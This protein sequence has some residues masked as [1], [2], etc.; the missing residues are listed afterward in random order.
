MTKETFFPTLRRSIQLIFLGFSMSAAVGIAES[1][2][3]V[4]SKLQTYCRS[5]HGVSPLRFFYSEDPGQFMQELCVRIAPNSQKTWAQ[6]II[7]VISWPTDQAP[8]PTQVMEP[9]SRDWMPRGA[10]RFAFSM[11]QHEGQL[12]RHILIDVVRNQCGL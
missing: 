7:K 6:Q 3:F 5:C 10:K 11:D 1:N 2:E 9:P 8:D 12:T 4:F